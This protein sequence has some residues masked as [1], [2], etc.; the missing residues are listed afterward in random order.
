MAFSLLSNSSHH[1]LYSGHASGCFCC[2]CLH[3]LAKGFYIAITLGGQPNHKDNNDKNNQNRGH[4]IAKLFL[5]HRLKF[6]KK[7]VPVIWK[8]DDIILT[9]SDLYIFIIYVITK[10]IIQNVIFFLFQAMKRKKLCYIVATL[11][12]V[13]VVVVFMIWLS[14]QSN[15]NIRTYLNLT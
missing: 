4:N 12:V 1:P 5:F 13:F 3:D 15:C 9:L 10:L 14:T 7:I 6:K 11:L 2:C 8:I